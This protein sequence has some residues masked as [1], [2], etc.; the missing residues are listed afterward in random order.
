MALQTE[1]LTKEQATG[2][3][4]GGLATEGS[5]LPPRRRSFAALRMTRVMSVH[6]VGQSDPWIWPITAVIVMGGSILFWTFVGLF[7]LA[8]HPA[9]RSVVVLMPPMDTTQVQGTLTLPSPGGRGFEE[10]ADIQEIAR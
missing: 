8:T 3:A 9:Q 7:W 6:N 5:G 4:E 2:D 1:P 10:E